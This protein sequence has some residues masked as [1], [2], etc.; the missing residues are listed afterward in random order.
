MK[1]NEK[2]LPDREDR[3]GKNKTED[4]NISIPHL[5]KTGAQT[6]QEHVMSSDPNPTFSSQLANPKEE[7][8]CP[9]QAATRCSLH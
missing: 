8:T 9:I 4:K 1:E 6:A 3:E 5:D 2:N 7:Y